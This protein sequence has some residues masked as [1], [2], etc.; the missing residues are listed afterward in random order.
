MKL[1]VVRSGSALL[2]SE[3]GTRHVN[4]GDVVLLA[5]QTLCGS[6]P[7]GSITTT[8]IYLDRDYLIDQVFWQYAAQFCDR[9]NARDFFDTHYSTPAQIVRIGEDRAGLLMPWLDELAALSLNGP[10]P[11]R[12]LRAQALLFSVLDVVV[13]FMTIT[14]R[15]A[16]AGRASA[17]VP[18]APRHRQFRPLRIEAR[19]VAQIIRDDLSRQWTVQELAEAAH[20]SPSQL[21]RVFVEAFG[22]APIAYLTMV[23]TERM[24]HLLR[25]TD[26][27]IK[28]IAAEAGWA[29]ADFAA[30]Q[31]RRALGVSPSVYRR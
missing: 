24:A 21:R 26:L 29:D 6:E 11:E 23:R 30:R 25:S 18:S 13:P 27:P 4:V 20:L 9:H 31:F 10:N 3:F 2:F 12:F 22:K 15:T 28:L 5:A 19:H 7:E 16:S 17:G 1:I 14:A 8:T